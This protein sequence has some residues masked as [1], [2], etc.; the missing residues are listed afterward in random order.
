MKNVHGH[1]KG[2]L[3]IHVHVETPVNLS[4]KQKTIL[5][6]FQETEKGSNSPERNSFLE[7]LK[8]FF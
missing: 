4:T 1:G 8:V 3:L 2:D 6:Q 7:K 5:E